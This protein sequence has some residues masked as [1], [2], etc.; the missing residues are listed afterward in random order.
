MKDMRKEELLELVL[1]AAELVVESKT[2]HE[3]NGRLMVY[4]KCEDQIG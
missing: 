2:Q 4:R 3:A 1:K